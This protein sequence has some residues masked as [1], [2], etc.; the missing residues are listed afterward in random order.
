MNRDNRFKEDSLGRAI[1][2]K[3]GYSL[4]NKLK[5]EYNEE[6]IKSE[7]DNINDLWKLTE[8]VKKIRLS[9]K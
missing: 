5:E 8:I 2:E 3:Y 9:R 1:M 4:N 6:D 7:I